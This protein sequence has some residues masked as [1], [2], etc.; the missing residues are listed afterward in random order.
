VVTAGLLEAIGGLGLFLLGMVVMTGG[1]KALAGPSLRRSL[2]RFTR[3]RW[4]GALSGALVTAV[5][6][7]SS[8][9]TVMAVGFVGAGLMTF[10]QAFG[11]VLG[12]NL[13]T[14]ATGWLV[15]LFGFEVPLGALAF[16]LVLVGALLQ[17]LSRGRVAAVGAGLAGFGV[18]FVG[19]GMM[20]SGL[21]GFEGVVTPASFPADTRLGRLQLIGIGVAI[22][23]VT[24]SSSA[25][26]AL[27]LT[28]LVAGT[29]SFAQA[30][31]MVIGMD[32]GTTMTVVLA[33]IGGSTQVRRTAVSHVA[34][35]VITSAVA[36]GLLTPYLEAVHALGPPGLLEEHPELLLVG[37]HSTFNFVG[38]AV[39]LPFAGVFAAAVEW[40][41]R[42]PRGDA[43]HRLGRSLRSEPS[44][45]LD[46]VERTSRELTARVAQR[47][48]DALERPPTAGALA[49]EEQLRQGL[50]KTWEYT[51]RIP[52][53]DDAATRS[54]YRAAIHV[55][56]HLD[57]LL[58]RLRRE[59]RLATLRTDPDLAEP[60]A[61][62]RALLEAAARGSAE[63]ALPLSAAEAESAARALAT[64]R[65]EDR[66]RVIAGAVRHASEAAEIEARLDAMR[67]VARVGRHVWRIALHLER[68]RADSPGQGVREE[69][70]EGEEDG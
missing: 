57:R 29:L 5:L 38:L 46:A 69:G 63:G 66:Q 61:A 31:S 39:A 18:V 56:D 62:L 4:S 65:D 21:A 12:A 26:V 53:S 24:Q 55:A 19:I 23:V 10:P 16:P 50:T 70:E 9:T 27:A 45:A 14:T 34:F 64:R 52:A 54:R 6:Q 47:A 48:L 44:A 60:V 36:Y 28:A 33:S 2:R 37:F 17:L 32:L 40:L 42:I 58:S 11:V 1:L 59:A 35:N 7:S 25:G 20:Q 22:T 3:S 13:G 67:W 30:A 8:A 15:A 68:M 49:A 51:L 41:V 43:T